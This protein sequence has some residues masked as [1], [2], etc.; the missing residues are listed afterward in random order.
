M[1]GDDIPS[2]ELN[3][4]PA[5]TEERRTMAT[6]SSTRHLTV[7]ASKIRNSAITQTPRV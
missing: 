2:D 3:V 4:I 7:L 6:R 5:D 1:M